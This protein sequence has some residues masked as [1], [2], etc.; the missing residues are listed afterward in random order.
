MK[1]RKNRTFDDAKSI[2]DRALDRSLSLLRRRLDLQSEMLYMYAEK[3]KSIQS[4]GHGSLTPHFQVCSADGCLS[5][6]HVRWKRWFDPAK[7]QRKRNRM[8]GKKVGER[9]VASSF[10]SKDISNVKQVLPRGDEYKELRELVA[11][12]EKVREQRENMVGYLTSAL[13]CSNYLDV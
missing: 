7:E 9:K 8:Y 4:V 12:F 6:L 11:A 3:I 2:R 5:C 10:G 1:N 13:R